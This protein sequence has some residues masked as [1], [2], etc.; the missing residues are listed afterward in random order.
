MLAAVIGFSLRDSK[1]QGGFSMSYSRL[2]H[3]YQPIISF[4]YQFIEY[5]QFLHYTHL[6]PIP[7]S[8]PFIS[9]TYCNGL[10][11]EALSKCLLNKFTQRGQQKLTGG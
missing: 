8:H 10:L 6:G 3:F 2:A 4:E 11:L 5:C 7:A 9:S 1:S